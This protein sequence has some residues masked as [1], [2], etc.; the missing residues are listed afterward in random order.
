MPRSAL[1]D[2][3]AEGA[4][5]INHESWH[6][7]LVFLGPHAEGKAMRY[8]ASKQ[9]EWQTEDEA[10]E[11]GFAGDWNNDDQLAEWALNQDGTDWEF[12]GDARIAGD[13]E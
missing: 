12:N 4:F 3:E 1:T 9:R 10:K 8:I 5:A 11:S 7:A 13:D 6:L 2:E